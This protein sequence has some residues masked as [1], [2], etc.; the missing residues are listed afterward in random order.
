MYEKYDF[1]YFCEVNMGINFDECFYGSV[2]VGERGQI[3][4]PAEAREELGIK[5]GDKLLVMRDPVHPGL[6]VCSFGVMNEF[7]EE[8]KSRIMKAEQSEPYE[9]PEEK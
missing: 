7:L 2:T 9:A 1:V 3:V 5:P 8:I 4:I 6:M